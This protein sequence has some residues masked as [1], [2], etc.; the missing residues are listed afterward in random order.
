[1]SDPHWSGRV[2]T[3]HGVVVVLSSSGDG[4]ARAHDTATRL[5]LARKLAGIKGYDFAG[6]FDPS[7]RYPGSL[8]F[9]PDDT[10]VGADKARALGIRGERDLFGGVVPHPFVA[11]KAISHPLVT[12]EAA[13]PPG[14]SADFCATLGD[15]LLRGFTVFSMDDARRAAAIL[16]PLGPV[17]VKRPGGVGGRGQAVAADGTA[18]D[19][20]LE[21]ED[22]AEVARVGLVLEENLRDVTTHSVGQVRVAELVASY[23]GTQRLTADNHG[24]QVYGGS[25]L[26]VVRGDFDAL[27]QFDLGSEARLALARA[28]AYDRA[29]TACFPGFF[30]SRRNYDVACGLDAQGRRRCGVLEQSWRIGGSSPAEI[31]ALE[32]FR[33]DGALPA[34]RAASV[35]V[36]GAGVSVPPNA[37]VHYQ[38]VDSLLGRITKYAVVEPYADP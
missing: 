21:A 3:G 37:E 25:D 18:L 6:A 17:R 24:E 15:A 29:A 10:L 23:W 22:P 5:A 38:G 7:V 36:Y 32:A 27:L 30:A 4:E 34:V 13:A 1:M 28:R 31:A 2:T 11:T 14:W 16:L 8:Y 35:E 20:I 26:I 19:A 33:A 12:A 9:V